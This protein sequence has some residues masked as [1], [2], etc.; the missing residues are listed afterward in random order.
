MIKR[1]NYTGRKKIPHSAIRVRLDGNSFEASWNLEDLGLPSAAA[2]VV[3]AFASRSIDIRRFSYGTVAS[4]QPPSDR[5]IDLPEDSVAF[6]FRVV[7]QVDK[8]GRLLGLAEN[9]RPR[10][11]NDEEDE[12]GQQSIL[13]VNP[14]DLGH[15]V[16]RLNYANNRTWLEVNNRIDGIMDIVRND[17]RFF[18][19]VYPSVVK[20]ILTRILLIDGLNEPDGDRSDCRVQWLRWGVHWHPDRERPSAGEPNEVEEELLAWIDEVVCEFCKQHQ[21]RDKFALPEGEE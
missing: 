16:W 11:G 10:T 21:I 12:A 3:E 4:P 15:Q 14:I 5:T 18:A 20:E 1:Y 9:I 13:P 6:N 19:L 7:D 8:V 17:R 2:I